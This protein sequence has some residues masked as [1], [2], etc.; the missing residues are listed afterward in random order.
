[1]SEMVDRFADPRT[2]RK[3]FGYA[4]TVAVVGLS[5]NR[6][7]PSFFV[8]GYLQ[9]RGFR[10]VPVNPTANEILGEKS[11]PTLRDIPFK[12]DVVD[13]FRAPDAVPDIADNA[14]EIGARALWLQFGVIAP[15]AA[16]GAAAAGLDVVMDRCMKIEHGRYFGEM[17]WFG[18]NTGI[19]TAR[20]PV[21]NR[22]DG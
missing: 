6:L 1:V 8:A 16:A 3:I 20:R 15:V 17:H 7:R 14:V 13:V 12:V 22:L 19:V 11:Y 9:Y 2:I 10:I 4:R 5:P 18:L 21:R